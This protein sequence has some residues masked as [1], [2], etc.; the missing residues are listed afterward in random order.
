MT[1]ALT[2]CAMLLFGGGGVVYV[3]AEER[4]MRASEAREAM[5]LAN[6]LQTAF[7]NALRDRQ[8]QDVAETL[9]ALSH[10]DPSV[11]IFV[12]DDAGTLV[13]ASS[14]AT[15]TTD[16]H[17]IESAARARPHPIVEFVEGREDSKLILGVRLRDETPSS[18]SAIVLEKPLS[19]MEDELRA[20]RRAI[21]LTVAAFVAIVG[22]LSWA[23]ARTY[24]GK[25]LATLVSNMRRVRE[26]DL[27]IE[28]AVGGDDEVGATRFEFQNLV[29][30]LARERERAD[31]EFE[32]RRRMERGL[33]HADKLITLGQLSAV[34]AHEIGSPLQVLEGR[35]RALIK[36]AGDEH[37]TR[38]TAEIL[39]QQTTRI[40]RIVE[41]KLSIT[42][43]KPP[44][45]SAIDAAAPVR[46]V[47]ALVEL[48]ARRR[49]VAIDLATP[50]RT[51]AYADADQLQQVALNLVR[52]ALDASPPESR[53]RVDVGG[54]DEVLEVRVSDE[55]SGVPEPLRS[56][57]FDAF[58]TTK[59]SS[60]GSGLGLLV[61]RSI[62]Q[63]HGGT[64]RFDS[65]GPPGCTVTV[66]IP[67]SPHRNAS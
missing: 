12:F 8:L 40:A 20:M 4:S 55:G 6:S 59:I 7:E 21:G 54:D 1:T 22:A 45:R 37:A 35:A 32:A 23:I 16:T 46:A 39:V 44:M 62:V 3:R 47:V 51:D 33:Q 25:P 29:D 63:E 48:E 2:A 52:N 15:A 53:I 65:Y 58:F 31:L 36:H 50:G 26:G 24:V 34:L 67:R 56:K 13:S 60:G 11:G 5:L 27:G 49:R 14:G 64:V 57:L 43:R 66:R 61:V 30:A 38:R 42:R 18:P 9:E 28:R 19:G 41:Q 10:V 17:R